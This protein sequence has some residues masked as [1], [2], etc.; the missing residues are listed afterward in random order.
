MILHPD[1]S[2][3]WITLQMEEGLAKFSDALYFFGKYL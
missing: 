1:F 2:R 3:S